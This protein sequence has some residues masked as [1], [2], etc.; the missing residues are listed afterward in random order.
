[1][2]CGV[3]STRRRVLP[4]VHRR[5]RGPLERLGRPPNQLVGV[6]FAAQGFDGGTY[7]RVKPER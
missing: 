2:V 5:I 3:D 7:Y 6:G 4:S 1:M